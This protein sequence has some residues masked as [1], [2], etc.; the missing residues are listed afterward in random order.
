MIWDRKSVGF[1]HLQSQPS[2]PLATKKPS[3][4]EQRFQVW[5]VE[6]LAIQ[7]LFRRKWIKHTADDNLAGLAQTTTTMKY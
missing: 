4:N 2:P 6:L 3:K 7:N 5:S 1:Q